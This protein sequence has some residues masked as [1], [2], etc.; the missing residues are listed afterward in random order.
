MTRS[1]QIDALFKEVGIGSA[2]TFD[3][4]EFVTKLV[5]LHAVQ[6][7]PKAPV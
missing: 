2:T 4:N 5:T 1:S 6:D 7:R 3:Y